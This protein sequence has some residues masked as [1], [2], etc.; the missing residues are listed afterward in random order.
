MG[1]LKFDDGMGEVET[2][3]GAGELELFNGEG[4][5]VA[6]TDDGLCGCDESLC[7]VTDHGSENGAG[8]NAHVE[9]QPN[10]EAAY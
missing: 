4:G 2:A 7:E 3:V 9:V 6:K 8:E 10:S 1:D 5:E